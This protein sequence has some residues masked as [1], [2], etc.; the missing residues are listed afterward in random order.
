[1][2]ETTLHFDLDMSA[3]IAA[4]ILANQ[5]TGT[6][7]DEATRT[8]ALR[9]VTDFYDTIQVMK[10]HA[11][12]S[13]VTTLSFIYA[14][15]IIGIISSKILADSSTTLVVLYTKLRNFVLKSNDFSFD[16]YQYMKALGTTFYQMTKDSSVP[17]SPSIPV[18]VSNYKNTLTVV[19]LRFGC[20]TNKFTV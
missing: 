9:Y 1:M 3:I 12:D 20:I 11:H 14:G 17:S 16:N 19:N 2:T 6:N 5:Y 7:S 15:L 4:D 8:I 13:K 18:F 10:G